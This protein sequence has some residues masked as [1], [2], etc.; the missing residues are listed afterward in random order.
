MMEFRDIRKDVYGKVLAVRYRV[1]RKMF[2][3]AG[4]PEEYIVYYTC[5]EMSK[6][7]DYLKKNKKKIMSRE[8]GFC[9]LMHSDE[10]IEFQEGYYEEN[11]KLMDE[12]YIKKNRSKMQDNT[13]KGQT[14]CSGE[15]IGNVKIIKNASKDSGKFNKGDILVTGMTRVEFV[16]LLKKA[17]AIITDE[18]GITCHAAIISRELKI[19][20]IIGTRIATNVLKDG[21]LIEVD[22]KKGI[23]KILKKAN[24][25]H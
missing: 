4:I 23:I 21:D 9:A 14:A 1:A 8:N 2:K 12:F 5:L 22:A 24:D 3:E 7:L 18:G 6:G 17:S 19:P 13:I 16:P 25:E 15:V 10:R 11:E 20:C